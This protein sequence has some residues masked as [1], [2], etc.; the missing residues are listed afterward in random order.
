MKPS[1]F[2]LYLLEFFFSPGAF[3]T[4]YYYRKR[5]FK[6]NEALS[7]FNLLYEEVSLAIIK[8]LSKFGLQNNYADKDLTLDKNMGF[9]SRRFESLLLFA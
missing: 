6:S 1:A 4:I 3:A 7:P 5:S 9:A 2:G 8:H